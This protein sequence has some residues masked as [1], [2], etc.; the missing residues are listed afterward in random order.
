LRPVQRDGGQRLANDTQLYE[1]TRR[2]S[3]GEVL[4]STEQ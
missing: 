1:I 3:Y 4:L 2:S